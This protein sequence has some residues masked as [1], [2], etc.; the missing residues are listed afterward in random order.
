MY[1]KEKPNS[2]EGLADG[3]RQSLDNLLSQVGGLGPV[4]LTKLAYAT[5]PLKRMGVKKLVIIKRLGEDY[6]LSFKVDGQK[7]K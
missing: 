4:G 5:Y 1:Q 2:S 3:E 7:I 6:F